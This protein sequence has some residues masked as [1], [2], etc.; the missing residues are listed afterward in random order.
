MKLNPNTADQFWRNEFTYR[1][2]HT[3]FQQISEPTWK[4]MV[5]DW[6]AQN[7]DETKRDLVT[8]F[9]N[10][11]YAK[12]YAK[13][14]GYEPWPYSDFNSIKDLDISESPSSTP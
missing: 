8:L 2:N 7:T 9:N 3:N 10:S 13:Y 11:N 4:G 1:L 12:A 6:Q 14:F 5:K